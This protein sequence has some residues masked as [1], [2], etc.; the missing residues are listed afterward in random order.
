[1]QRVDTNSSVF[2]PVGQFLGVE[3]V[4]QLGLAVRPPAEEVSLVVE[5]VPLHACVSVSKG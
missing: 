3:D 2:E 4:G 1:M 5:V